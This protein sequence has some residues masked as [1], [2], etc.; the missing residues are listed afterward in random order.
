LID[1]NG[2]FLLINKEGQ[3]SHFIIHTDRT[4]CDF[5]ELHHDDK[6]SAFFINAVESRERI[7]FFGE[8]IGNRSRGS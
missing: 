1:K 7:P 8:G 3:K 4:L 6:E 2:N 5:V